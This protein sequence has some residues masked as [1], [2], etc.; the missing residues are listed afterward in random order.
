M[1]G[2]MNEGHCLFYCCGQW[3]V[4]GWFTLADEIDKILMAFVKSG[5]LAMWAKFR[6]EI[7]G[8]CL[9]M[10]KYCIIQTMWHQFASSVVINVILHRWLHTV[11]RFGYFSRLKFMSCEWIWWTAHLLQ[12]EKNARITL[13]HSNENDLLHKPLVL[14]LRLY[15]SVR[16]KSTSAFRHSTSMAIKSVPKLE[17]VSKHFSTTVWSV[18]QR[19]VTLLLSYSFHHT[20]HY[21]TRHVHDNRRPPSLEIV[22]KYVTAT[23]Q[24]RPWQGAINSI[25]FFYPI[26]GSTVVNF[27]YGRVLYCFF[28]FAYSFTPHTQT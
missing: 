2:G 5:V 4:A 19:N 17:S 14:F 6:R 9:N 28:L 7:Q 3:V 20:F 24:T 15:E 12:I 16:A 18:Q 26:W 22:T 25:P 10:I 21:R 23:R 13:A 27:T 8:A 1:N 11:R